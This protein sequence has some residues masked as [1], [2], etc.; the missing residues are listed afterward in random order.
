LLSAEQLSRQPPSP[1]RD[2]H[3]EG[4]PPR[5]FKCDEVGNGSQRGR[6]AKGAILKI[7]STLRMVVMSMLGGSVACVGRAELDQKRSAACG[8]EAHRDIGTEKQRGQ[9]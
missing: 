9:Q 8:H 1:R 6:T 4:Y 3:A 7:R 5:G 2:C